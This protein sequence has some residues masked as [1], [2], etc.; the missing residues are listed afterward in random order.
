MNF[1]NSSIFSSLLLCSRLAGR[2]VKLLKIQL[3]A[4]SSNTTYLVDDPKYSFLKDLELERTNA[5]VYNG[6][7]FGSGPAVKS[8]DPATGRIIAEVE[9]GTVN[10]YE[11]CVRN[12]VDAYKIWS[13]VPAPR[14]GEIVRQIGDELRKNL[15]PL[16]KLVSLGK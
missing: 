2:Q 6:R 3:R 5:G 4:M 9:T 8:I 1:V 12:A 7:W 10:D 16:G 13:N 15:E 14:R 11:D